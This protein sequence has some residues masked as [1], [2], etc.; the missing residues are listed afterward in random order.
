M[1]LRIPRSKCHPCHRQMAIGTLSG[2]TVAIEKWQ[3][4]IDSSLVEDENLYLKAGRAGPICNFH[5]KGK[6]R[7]K[8][9]G[10]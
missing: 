8:S 10:M 6:G 9:K 4:W 2:A 7:G 5:T 1:P 3:Q